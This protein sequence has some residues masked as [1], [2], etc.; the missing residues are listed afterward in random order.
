ML[1]GDN[2]ILEPVCELLLDIIIMLFQGH[3]LVL[4]TLSNSAVHN[5]NVK[6]LLEE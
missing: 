5:Q 4:Q 6:T 3:F 1:A 2:L